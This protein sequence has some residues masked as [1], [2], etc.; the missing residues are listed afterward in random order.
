MTDD[1][2]DI[3]RTEDLPPAARRAERR[4][5]RNGLGWWIAAL[6]V[7]VAAIA[8]AL[9]MTGR[10]EGGLT[11]QDTAIVQDRIDNATTDAQLA[12]LRA[13]RSAQRAVAQTAAA[14][15]VAAQ[16]AVESAAPAIQAAAQDAHA[17]V[18]VSVDEPVQ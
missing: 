3:E 17:A 11:S 12:A 7:I 13:T 16:S 10:D 9:L 2:D 15:D 14:T 4:L 18:A 6:A 8:V 1:T 5:I